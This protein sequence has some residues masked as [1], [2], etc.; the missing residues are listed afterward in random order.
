M[1]IIAAMLTIGCTGNSLK[2]NTIK[3]NSE[4]PVELYLTEV[5][6][7]SIIAVQPALMKETVHVSELI[8]YPEDD[9]I[10]M[11]F[12]F[13]GVKKYAQI[14][15][16]NLEKRIAISLNGEIVSTPVVKMKISNGACSVLL[17][18]EQVARFF[19]GLQIDDLQNV[20][21]ERDNNSD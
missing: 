15:E 16:N 20:S 5:Q 9:M 19:P 1:A 7:D 4:I 8:R 10:T 17:T 11:P 13:D 14:T 3:I 21:F 18:K 12:N 6:N 2:P